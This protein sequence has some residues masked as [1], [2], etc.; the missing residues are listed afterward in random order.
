MSCKSQSSILGA[1]EYLFF[2]CNKSLTECIKEADFNIYK[3][4][5]LVK[6]GGFFWM[7]VCG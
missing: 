3:A 5:P 2:E 6:G 4:V 1:C 7:G